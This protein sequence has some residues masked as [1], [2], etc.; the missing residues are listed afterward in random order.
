MKIAL[1][2]F[3]MVSLFLRIAIAH[4]ETKKYE[5]YLN[6]IKTLSGD[7]TQVNNKGCEAT[8]KIEISRPGKMRLTY[9]PPS[10]LLII[11]NGEWLMT[12]DQEANEV[13]YTSLDK[14]PAVFVLRPHIQFHE[15][16]EVTNLIPKGDIT[17]ISL[18]SKEAQDI[19]TLTLI[20]RNNPITLEGWRI[21]DAQGVETRVMLSRVKTN[22][23]LSSERFMIKDP[24]LMQQIF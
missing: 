8:G 2:A 5:D 17:E 9:N 21:L 13:D 16:L 24:S 18:M 23:N 1:Y 6:E 12:L 3:L 15:D 10:S 4:D 22:I 19:G 11:A 20:F 14:T 7:F